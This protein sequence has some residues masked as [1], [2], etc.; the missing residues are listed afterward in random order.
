MPVSVYV[1]TVCQC[2]RVWGG[3]RVCKWSYTIH[4]KRFA[5][6]VS[7]S[8]CHRPCPDEPPP[9]CLHQSGTLRHLLKPFNTSHAGGATNKC[10]VHQRGVKVSSGAFLSM[11][12]LCVMSHQRQ[13]RRLQVNEDLHSLY[14]KLT[15]NSAL[16]RILNSSVVEQPRHQT[17]LNALRKV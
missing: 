1:N 10:P 16:L 7:L 2:V 13:Q 11:V 14:F 3:V 8:M 17:S 9:G 5:G 12:G 6:H 15:A 4:V